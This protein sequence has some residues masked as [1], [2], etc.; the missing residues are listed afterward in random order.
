MRRVTDAGTRA[1]R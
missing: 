1:W